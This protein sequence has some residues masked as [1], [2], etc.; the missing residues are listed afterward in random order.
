MRTAAWTTRHQDRTPHGQQNM[1]SRRPGIRYLLCVKNDGYPASLLVRG[2]YE[3]LPDVDRAAHGLVR[4]IDECGDDY[5]YPEKFFAGL[6][7]GARERGLATSEF[8]RQG[9]EARR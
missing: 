9:V 5:L 3:Q 6:D 4:I 1:K 2:L 7:G 8:V